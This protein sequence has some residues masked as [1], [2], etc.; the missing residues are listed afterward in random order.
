MRINQK[1]TATELGTDNKDWCFQN[2]AD[3]SIAAGALFTRMTQDVENWLARRPFWREVQALYYRLLAGLEVDRGG[4]SHS[5]RVL[6]VGGGP[7]PFTALEIVRRTGARVVVIDCDQRAVA[8]SRQVVAARGLSEQIEVRWGDGRSF[9]AAG[10]QVVHIARQAAPCME[11]LH[12]IQATASRDTRVL[13][14]HPRKLAA[15]LVNRFSSE[16]GRQPSPW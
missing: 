8:A 9:C 12:N 3:G 6:C 10:F 11:I 13:W 2:V 4:I 1:L 16:S 7:L 5:D 14:R 15:C